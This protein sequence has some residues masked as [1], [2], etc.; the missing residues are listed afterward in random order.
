M[1]SS[2]SSSKT[3]RRFFGVNEGFRRHRE[4]RSMDASN[5]AQPGEILRAGN[6]AAAAIAETTLTE[7]RRVKSTG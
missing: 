6:V 2:S 5:P 1:V 7:D 3:P 4:R